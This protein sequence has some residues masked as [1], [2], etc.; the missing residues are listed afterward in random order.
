VPE[1]IAL[2][3][4]GT[5][6]YPGAVLPLHV[7][8]DRYRLMVARLTRQAR[9]SDAAGEFGVVAI[10]LGRESGVDGVTALHEVGCMA[11]LQHVD[12]YPDGRFDIVTIGARRFRL[13]HVDTSEPYLQG[14]VEWLDEPAGSAA[15]VLAAAVA[16]RF[17]AYREAVLGP[18]GRRARG[19]DPLPDDPTQ[20]SY[21]VAASMVLDLGD[22]QGLLNAA[23]AATRLRLELD[24]LRREAALQQQLPSLPGVDLARQPAP[25]N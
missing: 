19:T 21:L 5:V 8:E 20:V 3:P 14:D 6:L 24:L 11:R 16:Q 7:F 10:R 23:D 9:D 18:Q 1:R 17:E 13:L 12:P 4:L 22:H 2:F 15:P 25:P